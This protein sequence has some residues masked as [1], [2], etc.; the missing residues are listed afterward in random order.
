MGTGEKPGWFKGDKYKTVAEQAAAYPA[1]E[2]R[3]GSFVG[4]PKDGKYEFKPPEG[5]T[6][7]LAN[8]MMGAFTKWAAEK[9]L[10]QDG[11]N[12]L[13]GMLVQYDAGFAPQPTAI[14][15]SLGEN[16]DAR[17]TAVAQ[18]G[19]ANLGP[20]GYAA[21]RTAVALDPDIHPNARVSAAFKVLEQIIGK[22]TQA[23]VP[24]VDD[25]GPGPTAGQGLAAI[26]QAHFKK[27][28]DGKPLVDTDPAYRRQVDQMY[29]D[30]YAAQPGG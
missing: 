15:S 19:K 26:Q 9:Q 12:E 8:P 22:T 24:R 7:D 2:S 28:A 14:K 30:Y 10:S 18:W 6:V 5:V 11:Y 13:L 16:A 27:G 23:K 3:F 17:I 25:A 21:L 20:D 4:A 1:L 29:R